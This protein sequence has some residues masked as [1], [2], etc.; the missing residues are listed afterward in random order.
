MC[1]PFPD[2]R[3]CYDAMD[4]EKKLHTIHVKIHSILGLEEPAE[5]PMMRV[6]VKSMAMRNNPLLVNTSFSFFI[7]FET[8]GDAHYKCKTHVAQ[9]VPPAAEAGAKDK[10]KETGKGEGR[11]SGWG[12]GGQQQCHGP[13]LS[14]L[15]CAF[16]ITHNASLRLHDSMPLLPGK[17]K[18]APAAGAAA[19]DPSLEWQKD[20]FKFDCRS[21]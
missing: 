4:L 7:K 8:V 14:Y 12:F 16:I 5:K 18:D 11:K 13:V 3:R 15:S 2:M 21:V 6:R 20:A 1:C 19:K 9:Y 10:G 17:G